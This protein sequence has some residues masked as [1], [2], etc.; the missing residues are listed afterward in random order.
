MKLLLE[1]WR[2]FINEDED[3]TMDMSGKSWNQVEVDKKMRAKQSAEDA[4]FYFDRKL[5]KGMMGEVY[6]V[7]NKKTGER[8]AMK[9]VVKAL[10]GG[11]R[12]SKREAQNYR[13]AMDNKES[14]NQKFAKYLPDVYNVVETTKDYFIQ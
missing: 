11:P 13:F 7:E 9:H 10:Y 4:G 2:K 5:G 3:V 8:N 12:T 6:L 1:N 14:M